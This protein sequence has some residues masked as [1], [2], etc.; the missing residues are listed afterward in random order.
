MTPMDQKQAMWHE[1]AL[2][3]AHL[4]GVGAADAAVDFDPGVHAA[5]VAQ[6][7]QLADLLNLR[8]DELLATKAG[9]DCT[10]SHPL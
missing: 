3:G 2:R 10:H 7:A 6:V 9:V 8:G 1:S 4:V 5:L